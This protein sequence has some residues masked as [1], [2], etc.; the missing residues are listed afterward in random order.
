MRERVL[1]LAWL[2]GAA[3]LLVQPSAQAHA[4][5]EEALPLNPGWQVSAGASLGWV[6]ARQAWPA[7]R[8]EGVL[9][10]GQTQPSREGELALEQASLGLGLRWLPWLGAELATSAHDGERPHTDTARLEAST[11]LAGGELRARLGRQS[12]S[13]GSTIDAAGH[14]DGFAQAPLAKLA[15]FDRDWVEDG[16]ALQWQRPED[17]EAGAQLQAL[18][19][20]LWRGRAFPGAPQGP[21]VPSLRL[22]GGWEQLSA[23]LFGAWLQPQGRGAAAVSSAT[24]GHSHG[25]P[26]C[27][28][29]LQ[30]RVCF[31]GRT[32]IWG[33]SLAQDGLLGGRFSWRL[34]GVLRRDR[35]TLYS[36][37]AT[38]EQRGQVA[39]WWAD[40][41]WQP[42]AH[43]ALAARAE[44]LVPRQTLTGYN[45]AS[46]AQDAG[47]S[48][49]P[50]VQRFTLALGR[51]WP[52]QGLNLWLE[53]GTEK[54]GAAAAQPWVG[55]RLQWLAPHGLQGQF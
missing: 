34:A 48:T 21:A 10:T 28:Q 47:L 32:Q 4:L 55:L 9:L 35:G 14:F 26:D 51:R 16:L 45:L 5:P 22:S 27:R 11:A 46:L 25:V 43:W 50:P 36:S 40:A 15:A 19:L 24:S 38:A 20:G 17:D 37:S 53:L 41:A 8:Y 18:E 42:D 6:K 49:A 23:E 12:L 13:L 39:G 7:A 29:S 3:A 30:N 2:M 52:P 33:A 54:A 1:A 31:E 44:R